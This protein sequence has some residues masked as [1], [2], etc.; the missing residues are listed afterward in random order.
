MWATVH[1]V[2]KSWTRLSMPAYTYLLRTN[3]CSNILSIISF[4]S[5][6][7]LRSICMFWIQVLHQICDWK[8]FSTR[9]WLG[10][11]FA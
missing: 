9:L 7:I 3:L 4:F 1:R 11:S 10:F 5:N 8:I 6:C 2:T